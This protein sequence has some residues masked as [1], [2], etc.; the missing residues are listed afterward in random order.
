MARIG[1]PCTHPR[2]S[3]I[4]PYAGGEP[5]ARTAAAALVGWQVRVPPLAPGR[6]QQR[7]KEA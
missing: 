2:R 1:R 3:A 4:A 6:P 5:F 7:R